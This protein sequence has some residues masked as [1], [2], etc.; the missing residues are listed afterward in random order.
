MQN[1]ILPGF[2]KTDGPVYPFMSKAFKNESFCYCLNLE[3]PM[4]PPVESALGKESVKHEPCK[5]Q[6]RQQKFCECN[7]KLVLL[8]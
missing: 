5:L 3:G 4:R 2:W 1:L 8:V 6:K 7:L